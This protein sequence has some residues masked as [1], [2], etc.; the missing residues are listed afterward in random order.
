MIAR[1][2]SYTHI[3]V[4][5]DVLTTGATSEALAKLLLSSGVTR[6]SFLAV[7]RAG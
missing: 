1:P 5:D 6:V 3:L 4:I 2:G 7:A